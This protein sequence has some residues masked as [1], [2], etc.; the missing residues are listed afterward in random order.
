MNRFAIKKPEPCRH[1]NTLELRF[2]RVAATALLL[3]GVNVDGRLYAFFLRS[4]AERHLGHTLTLRK[5][6][7]ITAP[8]QF[9][10]NAAANSRRFL[11]NLVATASLAPTN[12]DPNDSKC[13]PNRNYTV[14][15]SKA[16]ARINHFRSLWVPKYLASGPTGLDESTASVRARSAPSANDRATLPSARCAVPGPRWRDSRQA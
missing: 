16:P 15:P 5:L 1:P 11:R 13:L 9:V 12:S 10:G 8:I 7:G 4:V 6:I 14:G 2:A 3:S